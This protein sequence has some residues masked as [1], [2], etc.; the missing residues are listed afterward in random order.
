MPRDLLI[1]FDG[2]WNRPDYDAD[3]KSNTNTN[4]R[5][6]FNACDTQADDGS[7]QLK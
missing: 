4:V 5:L 3:V 1:C 6:F 2:T 7:P